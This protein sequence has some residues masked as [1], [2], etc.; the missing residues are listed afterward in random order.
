MLE[1]F[2]KLP[3]K[4]QI[5]ILNAAGLGIEL[6]GE[7]GLKSVVSELNEAVFERKYYLY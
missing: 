7:K 5:S 1:T 2:K 6:F 3:E 4:K